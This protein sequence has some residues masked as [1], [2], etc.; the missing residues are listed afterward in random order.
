M[1]HLL[2]ELSCGGHD[3]HLGALATLLTLLQQNLGHTHT[4]FTPQV[5]FDW[6]AHN[7][8]LCNS[9]GLYHPISHYFDHHCIMKV[10]M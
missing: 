3:E 5:S 1:T 4:P 8:S 9:E 2:G 10:Y 6:R 7:P